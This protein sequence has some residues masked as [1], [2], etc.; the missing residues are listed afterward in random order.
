MSRLW[1]KTLAFRIPARN[2]CE[3]SIMV[4]PQRR[5]FSAPSYSLY[6]NMHIYNTQFCSLVYRHV[7]VQLHVVALYYSVRFELRK[8]SYPLSVNDITIRQLHALM[9]HK[10]RN[11]TRRVPMRHICLLHNWNP[12]SSSFCSSR[13]VRLV[14]CQSL[15]E[16]IVLRYNLCSF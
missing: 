16:Q 6:C 14:H 3:N 5:H 10:N 13:K 2:R 8:T 12:I 4:S 15:S 9:M 1:G 11:I 7:H